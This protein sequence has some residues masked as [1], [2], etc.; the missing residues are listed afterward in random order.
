MFGLHLK[1]LEMARESKQHARILKQVD[2]C[3]NSTL[4]R[5]ATN[6][7]KHMLAEF[8]EYAPKFYN[9]KTS[10]INNADIL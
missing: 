6:I 2:H 8:N 3:G 5:R 9:S 10:P 7:G 1:I 4:V